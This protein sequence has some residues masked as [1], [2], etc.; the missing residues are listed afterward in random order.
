MTDSLIQRLQAAIKA[1]QEENLEVAEAGY[2]SIL[3]E[4]PDQSDANHNLGVIYA[5]SNREEESLVY[6]AAAVASKPEIVQYWISYV[7][8]FKN[9]GRVQE[10]KDTLLRANEKGI[11]SD[12][13]VQL[14]RALTL[15]KIDVQTLPPED[16]QRLVALYERGDFREAIKAAEQLQNRYPNAPQIFDI[17]GAAYGAIGDHDSAIRYYQTSLQGNQKNPET[18]HNLAICLAETGRIDEAVD[19]YL[20]AIELNPEFPEAQNNL[21]GLYRLKGNLPAAL[22]CFN[23]AI[24]SRP[25]WASPFYNLGLAYTDQGDFQKAEISYKKALFL[26]PEN[27]KALNNLGNLFEK[28]GLRF[29]TRQKAIRFL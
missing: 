26:E 15:D 12:V 4:Y 16:F 13:L 18:Y 23:K 11:Q 5:Q 6:F 28:N 17:F 22:T 10:A 9:M 20:Q 1:H 19:R 7:N 25:D 2:L 8:T 14:E 21:G 29:R 27:V 3:R 24:S